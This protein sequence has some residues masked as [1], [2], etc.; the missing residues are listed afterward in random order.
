M[1]ISGCVASCK[2]EGVGVWL[3]IAVEGAVLR[4]LLG[5]H[6]PPATGASPLFVRQP[7][8]RLSI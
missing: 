1:L 6:A 8:P 7:R 3:P 4:R 2:M 5:G